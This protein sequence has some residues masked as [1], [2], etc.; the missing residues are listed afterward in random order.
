[1]GYDDRGRADHDRLIAVL[2]YGYADGA[3]LLLSMGSVALGQAV[4]VYVLGLP[5]MH[6]LRRRLPERLLR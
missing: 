6:L 3:P 5:L 1:M 4:V 2:P